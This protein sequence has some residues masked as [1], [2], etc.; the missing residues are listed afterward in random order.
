MSRKNYA[1]DSH[2]Q[3]D[4]V[5]IRSGRKSAGLS[6]YLIAVG[7]VAIFGVILAGVGVWVLVGQRGRNERMVPEI[8]RGE[9]TVGD[10]V[11]HFRNNNLK[12]EYHP[13]LA[14][15][16]GAQE[17]GSYTGEGFSVEIYRFHDVSQAKSLEKTSS[18]RN[19]YYR[20]GKII[21]TISSGEYRVLPEFKKF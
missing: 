12:G 4:G 3:D 1:D 9:D 18:D 8:V 19:T 13:K 14:S 11:S 21:I 15:L 6:V 16:I 2:S 17:G 20:S 7:A 5:P 10:L